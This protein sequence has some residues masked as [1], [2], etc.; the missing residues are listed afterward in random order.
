M[1]NVTNFEQGK[2]EMEMG[3]F[4]SMHTRNM[5]NHLPDV[6][7]VQLATNDEAHM[8]YKQFY[9]HIHDWWIAALSGVELTGHH[10]SNIQTSCVS[11]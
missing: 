9:N 7:F 1:F 3:D 2:T 6:T 4:T 5:Q 8:T 11:L 10:K